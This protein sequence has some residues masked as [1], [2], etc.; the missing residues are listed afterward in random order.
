MPTII[1]A[2]GEQTGRRRTFQISPKAGTLTVEGSSSPP[3]YRGGD[4][5]T[6]CRRAVGEPPA[7]TYFLSEGAT[8]GFFDEDAD[9]ESARQPAPVTPTFSKENGDQV[10]ATR[11]VTITARLTA[12]V[13]SI[14]GLEAKR[15]YLAQVRPTPT[16]RLPL[17][18]SANHVLG[19]RATTRDTRAALS[20]NR[21]TEWFFAEGSP[22]FFKTFVL[23]IN[24]HST[25]TDVTF[26][27][28]RENEPAAVKTMTLGAIRAADA[29]RR[30]MSL[31]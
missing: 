27:F 4:A 26:T 23:G 8:G 15:P 16:R 31:N 21:R 6:W 9:R 14:P 12:D 10:A 18:S 29:A 25:P 19:R 7:I 24:P 1:N 22:G 13:E 3:L 2:R 17:A 5:T 20:R 30:A 11:T 28:F